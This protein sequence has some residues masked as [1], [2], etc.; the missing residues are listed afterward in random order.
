VSAITEPNSKEQFL[1][2]LS[3]KEIARDKF[4]TVI[5]IDD[6]VVFGS[7]VKSGP[8]LNYGLVTKI[9]YNNIDEKTGEEKVSTVGVRK[10]Q[11][12]W[13]AN[14]VYKLNLHRVS[15]KRWENT[16]VITEFTPQEVK[17][18]IKAGNNIKK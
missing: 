7:G 5:N 11:K 8:D 17:D 18:A 2:L 15:I 12:S 1:K 16:W 4:G 10:C 3:G 13:G 6:I 14:G 9:N